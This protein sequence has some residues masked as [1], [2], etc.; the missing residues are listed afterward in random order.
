MGAAR[1]RAGGRT[2][3]TQASERTGS[4]D[5]SGEKALVARGEPG[6]A[7]NGLPGGSS[8]NARP[9]TDVPDRPVAV[10]EYALVHVNAYVAPADHIAGYQKSVRIL[11]T[12]FA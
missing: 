4:T 3:A 2:I 5:K 1:A 8:T 10:A 7:P 12:H 9:S 6:I 11:A